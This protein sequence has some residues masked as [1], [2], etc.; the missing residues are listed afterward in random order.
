MNISLSDKHF[1]I[2]HEHIQF[3]WLLQDKEKIG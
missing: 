1:L 2:I 3:M